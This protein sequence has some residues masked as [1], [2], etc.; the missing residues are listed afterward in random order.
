MSLEKTEQVIDNSGKSINSAEKSTI[1]PAKKLLRPVGRA[2]ADYQMI[3][4]DDHLLLG[5][6]GGK[7]SLTLLHLL[8]H[9]QSY[10]PVRFKL[11]VATV[12]PCI[13]GFDPSPLKEYLVQ[14]GID[15]FYQKQQIAE[16]A[17]ENMSGDS[18]CSYC[19]RMRRGILYSVARKNNCNKLVLAQ[20]LDDLCLLYTSDAAD[21]QGLV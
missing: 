17:S 16:Q 18:F 9:L 15:Y 11:A 2:I 8:H 3:Q 10:A 5:L 7:D 21:D 13:E 12:D 14:L 1:K 4:H 20:H 19:S 6:S